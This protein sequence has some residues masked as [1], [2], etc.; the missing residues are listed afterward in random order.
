MK[1]AVASET[2]RPGART[3]ACESQERTPV[4][5]PGGQAAP[6][7]TAVPSPAGR[8]RRWAGRGQGTGQPSW[9]EGAQA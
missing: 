1:V 9:E 3:A 6:L 4:S 2:E 5:A 8:T 7:E